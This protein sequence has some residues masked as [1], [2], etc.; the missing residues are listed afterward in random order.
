MFG[1]RNLQIP[2]PAESSETGRG[3]GTALRLRRTANTKKEKK[4]VKA[5]TEGFDPNDIHA[6][7]LIVRIALPEKWDKVFRPQARAVVKVNL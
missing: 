1:D 6:G 7:K 2:A 4:E 3:A 5:G